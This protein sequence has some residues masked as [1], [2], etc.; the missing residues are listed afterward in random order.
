MFRVT[1]STY[2]GVG[3]VL[4]VSCP[5]GQNLTTGYRT[6][7]T[8]CSRSGNWAPEVPECDGENCLLSVTDGTDMF[9]N[10][11]YELVA[12]FYAENNDKMLSYRRETA[13]QGALQISPKVEH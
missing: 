6:M 2:T 9:S 8:I 10:K 4:N 13:L 1:N 5:A 3:T 7:T 12:F 11:I